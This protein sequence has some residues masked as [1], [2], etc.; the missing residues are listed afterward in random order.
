MVDAHYNEP[1]LVALY[2]EDNAGRW[3]TDF[4]AGLLGTEP[5]RIADVGCGTGSFAVELTQA[6][7]TVTGIDPAAGMLAAARSRPGSELVTWLA[8]TAEDLPA[9]P[10]DAAVMTGHAFQCL[11]TESEMLATLV[12]V[13]SRLVPG[14]TFYFESRNPAAKAWLEWD[15]GRSGP[16]L[17]ESSAGTLEV[18]WELISVQEE[19]DGAV[20]IFED[21]TTFLSDGEPFA[22]RS[23]LKFPPADLLE[24]LLQEAGFSSTDWYGDWDGGPFVE[25]TSREIIIAARCHAAAEATRRVRGTG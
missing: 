9:G 23:T 15:S 11:L 2:D 24:R 20:V 25:A 17:Q 18:E 6:G 14:G 21:R 16:E 8:G 10:F 22:S 13:R 12:A 4:Y 1:R 5:L 19:N 7:H 3:D